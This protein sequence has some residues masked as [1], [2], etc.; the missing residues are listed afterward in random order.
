[1][2]ACAMP[3]RT[4]CPIRAAYRAIAVSSMR[5]LLEAR[6][7]FYF[8]CLDQVTVNRLTAAKRRSEDFSDLIIR[9]ANAQAMASSGS[10]VAIS[11]RA[12]TGF[13]PSRVPRP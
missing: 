13:F 2:P 9:M 1:M 4:A 5:L 10:P 11:Y 3:K 6:R 12:Q 8:L 7:A